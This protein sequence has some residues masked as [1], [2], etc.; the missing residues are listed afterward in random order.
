MLA[1]G[2]TP[3]PACE[4]SARSITC[5][6]SDGGS[7]APVE[8]RAIASHTRKPPSQSA[9]FANALVTWVADNKNELLRLGPG[10]HF[11]EWRGREFSADTGL[12]R[13]KGDSAYSTFR[14]GTNIS[15]KFPIGSPS[16]SQHHALLFFL[17]SS[18]VPEPESG[19]WHIPNTGDL[20]ML[21]DGRRLL[22]VSAG[23]QSFKSPDVNDTHLVYLVSASHIKRLPRTAAK[24]YI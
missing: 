5:A 16:Q 17:R 15:L 6:V 1:G 22:S 23:C 8:V 3:P 21:F 12:R 19:T 18:R 7:A 4:Y 11:G 13:T 9:F 10:C 14:A 2:F 24:L 20:T